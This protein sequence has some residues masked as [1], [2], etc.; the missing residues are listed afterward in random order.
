[1]NDYLKSGNVAKLVVQNKSRVLVF[2]KDAMVR[3]FACVVLGS[4]SLIL[5]CVNAICSTCCD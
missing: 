4:V 5:L 2:A 1:M 3:V